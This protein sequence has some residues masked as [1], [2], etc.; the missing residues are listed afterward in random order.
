MFFHL[1]T[2][3]TICM[4]MCEFVVRLT[5]K[6]EKNVTIYAY[7]TIIYLRNTTVCLIKSTRSSKLIS[8]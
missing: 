4:C 2:H 8:R 6:Q 1:Q 7:V 3:Y 5:F